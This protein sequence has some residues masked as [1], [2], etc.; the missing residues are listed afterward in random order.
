MGWHWDQ[1]RVKPRWWWPV[2]I[3]GEIACEAKLGE[4]RI[5]SGR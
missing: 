2:E 4:E 1:H 3:K 5:C